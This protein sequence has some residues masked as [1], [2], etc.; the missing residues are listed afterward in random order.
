ML[1]LCHFY[2]AY[3][4]AVLDTEGEG[5]MWSLFEI[6]K[7]LFEVCHIKFQFREGGVGEY[8]RLTN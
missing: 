8:W 6:P 1:S 5:D 7:D 4:G 2:L 3:H